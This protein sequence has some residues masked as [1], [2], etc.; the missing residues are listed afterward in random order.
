MSEKREP[1]DKPLKDLRILVMEDE[2]LIAMDV[3]QICHDHGAEEVVIL[4]TLKELDDRTIIERGI[5][6]AV[7][8]VMLAGESTVEFA[9]SLRDRRVPFVFATGYAENEHLFEAF[10]GIRVVGKPYS[11]PTLITAIV[12]AMTE[13]ET[14]KTSRGV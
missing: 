10:P 1:G 6:V 14:G 7:V 13:G 12:E 3:E 11:G 8:D 5:S 2:F 9:R 4:R